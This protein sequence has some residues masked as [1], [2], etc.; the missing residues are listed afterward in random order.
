MKAEATQLRNTPVEVAA[1]KLPPPVVTYLGDGRWRLEAD[2][3]YQDGAHTITVPEG[4]EFDLSSVPHAFWW[5]ISPFDLSVV[6]P[7]MHDYLYKYGGNPP[8]GSI[9]PHRTYTR[10][11]VDDM[12]R[13]IMEREGVAAWRRRLA[14][15]A[16]TVFGRGG[17]RK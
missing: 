17:W 13:T 4:F 6:A 1:S 15:W 11:E 16:V 7:L 2:Y 10:R 9:V 14:Y 12:F 3:T 8:E 5:L